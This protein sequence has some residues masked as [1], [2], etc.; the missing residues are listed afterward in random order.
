MNVM[1]SAVSVTPAGTL[2]MLSRLEVAKL[3]SAGEG[4]L[5]E[6][7]RRCALAVLNCGGQVDDAREVYEAYSDFR[8]ELLQQ[9]RGVKLL[10]SN[11]PGDAFVDG[12]LIRGIRDHLFSVLRDV[13][14]VS[15]EIEG[16]IRPDDPASVTDAVFQ[17]LRNAGV[18]RPGV[19]PNLVVC[20]GGHSIGREEYDY[21]KSVGYELGLRG[22]DVCTGC[23]PGAMK[24]PMKGAAVGHAK[25]RI[26][27][28]RYLGISEPSI[29]AAE[30]PN[31]IVNELVIMPD[32]EKRLEAFVR[33]GHGFVVFPGGVGTAEEV[34][35]LLGILLN[36]A[37]AELPFPLVFTG[38]AESEGYF[39][40][41]DDFIRTSL[42]EEAAALYEIVV[43][44]PAG[45]ARRMA[46]SMAA[47]RGS[48]RKTGDAFFF[49][50]RLAV[51]PDFQA[52]FPGTHEGMARLRLDRDQPVHRLAADLRRAF[53][54]IVAGNVKEHGIRAVEEHG[55]FEIRGDAGVMEPLDALLRAFVAQ[56]RMRL[57][58]VDYVPCYR[59]VSA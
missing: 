7:F 18:M 36:P 3:R 29:I 27:D 30:S 51:E 49:N 32:I 6:R 38:P 53:S 54:G 1:R 33:L 55:P 44:D 12:R 16:R 48:R 24:G 45:V 43:G 39:R 35:Y 57:P 2:D 5:G 59:V 20:W 58:G 14:Y 13:V 41:L 25:Q 21:S 22:L 9:E 50:W 26:T 10:I 40:Q 34:L 28:G 52:P 37:N 8:I 42:G 31:P 17:I 11:A 15:T 19:D 47:V 4:S 46:E 23:G 56:R